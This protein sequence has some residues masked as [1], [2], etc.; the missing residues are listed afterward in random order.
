M[1]NYIKKLDM[2]TN[3]YYNKIISLLEK[4]YFQNLI[5]MGISNDHYEII[6]ERVFKHPVIIE[7]KENNSIYN[8]E[9]KRFYIENSLGVWI[10]REYDENGKLLYYENSWGDWMKYEYNLNGNL[11]Y[12]ENSHGM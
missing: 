6:F 5:S 1:G 2:E 4:P 8:K 7:F 3:D 9:G 10:K 11:I 12:S